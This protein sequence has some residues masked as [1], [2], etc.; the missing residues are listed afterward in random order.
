MCRL[1]ELGI[2]EVK[3]ADSLFMYSLIIVRW[4]RNKD[5]ENVRPVFK[6]SFCIPFAI[7][8]YISSTTAQPRGFSILLMGRAS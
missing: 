7:C 8:N 4:C 2:S 5:E 1:G 3:C 6:G